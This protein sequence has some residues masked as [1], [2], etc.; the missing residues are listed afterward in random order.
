MNNLINIQ[1]KTV[2]LYG[3]SKKV[4]VSA[5]STLAYV[6]WFE[7]SKQELVFVW[8]IWSKITNKINI[9]E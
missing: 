5:T 6:V 1:T 7:V 4:D 3:L 2:E 9:Y 8:S